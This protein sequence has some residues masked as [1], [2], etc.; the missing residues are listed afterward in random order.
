MYHVEWQRETLKFKCSKR[1]I[2]FAQPNLDSTLSSSFLAPAVVLLRLSRVHNFL[3]APFLQSSLSSAFTGI[4]RGLTKLR[5]PKSE[6]ETRW[7]SLTVSRNRTTHDRNRAIEDKF[8]IPREK[9]RELYRFS[10]RLSDRKYVAW[11]HTASRNH[12]QRPI[13]R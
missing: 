10:L 7:A 13:E 9:L 5:R 4:R 6:G 2:R 12:E 8:P 3:P 1:A 11:S